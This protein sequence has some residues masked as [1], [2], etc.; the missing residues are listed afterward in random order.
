MS[1]TGFKAIY[2]DGEVIEEKNDFFDPE[3]KRTC[4]T[5]WH[6][7]D[8]KK[9]HTLELW[10]KGERKAMISK[11]LIPNIT[12]WIF[13]HTG[14]QDSTGQRKVLSRTIGSRNGFTDINV[15]MDE[16]TGTLS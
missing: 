4:A 10:W 12:S 9:L 3:L 7:V 14:S 2:A 15:T 16:E 6:Q 1:F 13:F 8:Q 5:N 11:D